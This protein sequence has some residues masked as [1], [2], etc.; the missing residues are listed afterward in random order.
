MKASIFLYICLLLLIIGCNGQVVEEKPVEDIKFTNSANMV[1]GNILVAELGKNIYKK[2]N[3]TSSTKNRNDIYVS[4][5]ETDV[6]IVS[7]E[8]NQVLNKGFRIFFFNNK[9]E[10]L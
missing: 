3:I 10:N 4:P 9:I 7:K 8:E 1:V 6:K 2:N 5:I